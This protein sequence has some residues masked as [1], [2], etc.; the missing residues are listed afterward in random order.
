MKTLEIINSQLDQLT[1]S[2][3]YKFEMVAIGNVS[4]GKTCMFNRY[5]KDIFEQAD[6]TLNF[7]MYTRPFKI[8]E[9]NILLS[10]IDTSGEEKFKSLTKNYVTNKQCILYVFSLTDRSSFE[11]LQKWFDWSDQYVQ[12]DIIR[13]LVGT[14]RDLDRQVSYMEGSSK[15]K[16]WRVKYFEVSSKSGYGIDKLFEFCLLK[17]Y[18][19][20]HGTR[21]KSSKEY[22]VFHKK[23]PQRNKQTKGG[24]C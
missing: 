12:E 20:F 15:A 7:N 3:D 21:R 4:T 9:K 16:D 14:Q 18:K 10:A 6:I 1:S 19:K 13:I 22:K 8:D 17:M 11:N 24:C 23:L 2:F 5:F